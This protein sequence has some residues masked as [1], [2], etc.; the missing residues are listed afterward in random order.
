MSLAVG[1][2]RSTPSCANDFLLNHMVRSVWG[3]EDALI[4]SDCLAVQSQFQHNHYVATCPE[5]AAASI[6]AG[7]DLNTGCVVH[8]V[9]HAGTVS[10]NPCPSLFP[11][12]RQ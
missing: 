6:N 5:A 11:R 9:L 12:R 3:A 1:S 8:Y 7:C 4:V 2:N 10:P